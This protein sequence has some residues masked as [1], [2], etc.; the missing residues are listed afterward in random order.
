[1]PQYYKY[2]MPCNTEEVDSS[3][4]AGLIVLVN[5]FVCGDKILEFSNLNVKL[6]VLRFK[7]LTTFAGAS[8]LRAGK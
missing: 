2:F 3:T 6:L 4:A 1:M 5:L 8:F 7:Y